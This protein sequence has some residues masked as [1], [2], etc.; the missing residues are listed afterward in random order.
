MVRHNRLLTIL[1]IVLICIA[2]AV[3][4]T[5]SL[6]A[7]LV[8]PPLPPESVRISVTPGIASS[9]ARKRSYQCDQ[10]DTRP[11][12]LIAWYAVIHP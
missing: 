9:T 2:L 1:A 5:T 7:P 3:P 6:A 11:A 12:A 8:L 10:P 4:Y